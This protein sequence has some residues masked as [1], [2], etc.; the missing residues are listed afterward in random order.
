MWKKV[1]WESQGNLWMID[2]YRKIVPTEFNIK[3]Q[4]EVLS[5]VLLAG[6]KHPLYWAN[7]PA[8]NVT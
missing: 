5:L 3:P 8:I 4:Q 6:I 1:L 2:M 7:G